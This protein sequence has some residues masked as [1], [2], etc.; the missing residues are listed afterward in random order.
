MK[1]SPKKGSYPK[2]VEKNDIEKFEGFGDDDF[3]DFFRPK[4]NN[5][6]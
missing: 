1:S 6:P 2:E 4:N 3:D 5:K